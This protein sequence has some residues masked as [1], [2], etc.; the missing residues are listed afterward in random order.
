VA[1][2]LNDL[3]FHSVDTLLSLLALASSGSVDAEICFDQWLLLS[4][5][6]VYLCIPDPLGSSRSP[7]VLLDKS[8]SIVLRSHKRNLL[9]RKWH[10]SLYVEENSRIGLIC[11]L[12][13]ISRL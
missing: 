3:A 4:P 1:Q 9:E 2:Y 6:V 5:K 12:G 13:R 8:S 11:I 7:H 10:C